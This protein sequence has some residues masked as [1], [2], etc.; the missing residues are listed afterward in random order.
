MSI[1]SINQEI[2]Q[3]VESFQN[4]TELENYLNSEKFKNIAIELQIENFK[5]NYPDRTAKQY[6]KKLQEQILLIHKN[7]H[8]SIEKFTLSDKK[9]YHLSHNMLSSEETTQQQFS[10]CGRIH[11]QLNDPLNY[12]IFSSTSLFQ[13]SIFHTGGGGGGNISQYEF[14]FLEKHLPKLSHQFL[15]DVK[16]DN[17]LLNHKANR[18]YFKPTTSIPVLLLH[19]HLNNEEYKIHNN[20]I[21]LDNLDNIFD[22]HFQQSHELNIKS[23]NLFFNIISIQA[24]FINSFESTLNEKYVKYLKSALSFM[25]KKENLEDIIQYNLTNNEAVKYENTKKIQEAVTNNIHLAQIALMKFST[26][27]EKIN[28]YE[29]ILSSDPKDKSYNNLNRNDAIKYKDFLNYCFD[30][31]DPI[32]KFFT[33]GNVEENIYY[34]ISASIHIDL[35]EE[36]YLKNEKYLLDIL[37]KKPSHRATDAAMFNF[38]YTQNTDGNP[39]GIQ[40]KELIDLFIHQYISI[41]SNKPLENTINNQNF[42][43]TCKYLDSLDEL[44]LN[45]NN[46]DISVQFLFLLTHQ[47]KH[48]QEKIENNQSINMNTE[49]IATIDRLIAK[50][51]QFIANQ[52]SQEPMKNNKKIKI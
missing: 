28:I 10:Y 37:Q 23:V 33:H 17:S 6:I 42:F 40:N 19:N 38:F 34:Y 35:T 15:F 22:T 3:H 25:S 29:T 27:E 18:L 31:K 20:Q 7:V 45:Q 30:P 41:Q 52:N 44:N 46:S 1:H 43:V 13:N 39:F 16:A 36:Q 5:Q 9:F 24:S 12:N 49:N 2:L 4:L 48:F 26:P 21:L 14:N 32:P 47:K 50:T 51:N 11:I 8:F